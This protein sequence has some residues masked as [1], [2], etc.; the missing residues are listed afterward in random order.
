MQEVLGGCFLLRDGK[1]NQGKG[2][3]V[4]ISFTAISPC[5]MPEVHSWFIVEKGGAIAP[6]FLEV[7]LRV[8]NNLKKFP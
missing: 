1:Q 7:Y 2:E 6:F 3:G 8:C 5:F 4:S